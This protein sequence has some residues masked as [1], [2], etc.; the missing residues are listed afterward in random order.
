MSGTQRLPIEPIAQRI[1]D[2]GGLENL[3]VDYAAEKSGRTRATWE[4]WL[5]RK[6]SAG[7]LTLDEADHLCVHLLTSHPYQV[8]GALWWDVTYPAEAAVS[9]SESV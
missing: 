6:I 1:R 8:Y 4:R 2:L 7:F 5:Y 3:P 9:A